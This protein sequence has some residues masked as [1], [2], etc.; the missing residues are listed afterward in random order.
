MREWGNWLSVQLLAWSTLFLASMRAC[1][2]RS[3]SFISS[4][5]RSMRSICSL[6]RRPVSLVIVIL[7]LLP[8]DLSSA[9]TFRMPLA[10]TSK[11][12]SI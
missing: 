5:S 10:S 9:L 1:A 11:A 6:V 8:V 2:L 3:C 7:F 12:T 4:A